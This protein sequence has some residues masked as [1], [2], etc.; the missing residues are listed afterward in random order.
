MAGGGDGACN[1]DDRVAGGVAGIA[2]MVLMAMAM[3]MYAVKAMAPDVVI[4]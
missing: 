2:M 3:A 1:D 4:R